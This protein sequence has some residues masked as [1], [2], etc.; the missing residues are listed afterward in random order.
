MPLPLVSRTAELLLEC[1]RRGG[2]I[3][4][5]GNGGS[6]AT[7]SHFACDL[8]KGTCADGVAAFSVIPLT[9]N[10]PLVSAWANDV[11]YERVVAEQ[12][13]ALV[14]PGDAVVLISGSG[15]SPNVV[16]AA[17]TAH[18]AGT[19]TVAWT[20]ATGGK[21]A[22]LAEVVVRVPSPAIEQVEDAHL[23]LAHSVCVALRARLRTLRFDTT[24]HPRHRGVSPPPI[25]DLDLVA[26]DA[27]LDELGAEL[28]R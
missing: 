25:T 28:A 24:L 23:M 20:G 5:L 10:M 1:H 27:A 7:A 6:A 13:A 11:S 18:S 3:F 16:A 19:L 12:L 8:A 22:R 17:K 4:M 21:V 9:D 15:D 14:R 26:A 2:I